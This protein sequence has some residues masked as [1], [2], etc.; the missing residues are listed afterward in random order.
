VQKLYASISGVTDPLTINVTNGHTAQEA[1]ATIECRDTSLDINSSI[2]VDLGYV[3]DHGVIFTGYVKVIEENAKPNT[4]TITAS[5]VLIRA[6]DYFIVTTNPNT[7][8]QMSSK[9]PEYIIG[10]LL[11]LAGM[12]DFTGDSSSYVWGVAGPIKIDCV[13]AYDYSK[14]L[15]DM[16]AWGFYAD[17]A[18]HIYFK[19]RRPYPM[20]GDTSI[21]T[22]TNA[23]LLSVKDSKNDRTLRNKVVV[24][25]TSGV[26]AEASASSAYLPANFYK[27]AIVS[28]YIIDSQSMA[29]A[30]CDF[31]L[32][33]YNRLS[34]GY[35]VGM[36]GNHI[37]NARKVCYLNYT[38]ETLYIYSSEHNWNKSGYTCNLELR[39]E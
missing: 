30:A 29:Q 32:N 10:Y 12:T 35:T 22:I 36:I 37:Y 1:T 14:M 31:N 17:E 4:I 3:D 2:T 39:K 16:I 13:S 28:S 21:G 27:T 24:W 34:R 20:G 38:A 26:Y 11:N 5:D 7:P 25:G 18:G 33:I 6:A 23:E 9:S 19:D 15:A 8:L